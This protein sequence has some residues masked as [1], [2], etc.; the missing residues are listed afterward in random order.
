MVTAQAPMDLWDFSKI[1]GYPLWEPV[2][3]INLIIEFLHYVMNGQIENLAIALAPR[4]GKSMEV[5]EIFPAYYMGTRPYAKVLHVSYS[6]RLAARFGGKAK[7][8]LDKFGYLFPEKPRLSPETKSKTWFKIDGKDGEY[9]CTGFRGGLL[10]RGGNLII[11]DD[12]IKTIEEARSDTYQEKLIDLFDTSIST[13]KEKDPITKQAAAVVVIHQRLDPN[14]LIGIILQSRDWISANDALPKLRAGEKLG[15]LW[16][17]LRLPELAEDNDILGRKPGEALW[18]EKRPKEELIQIHKDIGDYK[19]DAIHQQ[20]PRPR[21][22]KYFHENYFEVVDVKPTN[23]IKEVM[24]WDLAGTEYP[25][26]MPISQRGASTAGVRL[27]LTEDRKLYI[28]DLTEWWEEGPTVM[29]NIVNYCKLNGKGP[30]Y[31]IPQDPAQAGKGQVITYSMQLPGYNFAGVIEPTNM[32]KEM[33]AEPVGNWAKVNKIYVVKHD[34][35]KRFIN[36]C[37]AFPGKKQKDFVDALSGAY[38]EM[39]IP[40]EEKKQPYAEWID[41]KF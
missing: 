24:W 1:A 16:V 19:F 6:E 14:D 20:D 7:D 17:Y 15:Q 39:D 27:A 32:N 29:K 30:K 25:D 37:A 36:Q 26:D 3:H 10:G 33:R 9:F 21:E 4:L 34:L 35:A 22:G 5:S 31:I 18:P 40:T 8:T 2:P 11:V 41:L 38:G 23:I 13:R 28:T 12:P